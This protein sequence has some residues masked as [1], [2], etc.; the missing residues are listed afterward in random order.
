MTTMPTSSIAFLSVLL[1]ALTAGCT[2][3][4]TCKELGNCGGPVPVGD[5]VLDPAHPSCSENLYIPPG[6][7]RL[8][9]GDQPAARIPPADEALY[10]WCDLLVT[11]GGQKV[12]NIEPR[13]SYPN[14]TIGAAFF[15]YDPIGPTG[16]GTYS[17]GFTRTGRY[18]IEFPALCIRQFGAVGD[19]C[20]ALQTQLTQNSAHKDILCLANPPD[21]A[22][23]IC[24][25]D[26]AVQSGGSGI[27]QVLDGHTLIHEMNL[28]FPSKAPA[29][30]FP[31]QVTYCNKG[32]SLEITGANGAYLFDEPGLRTMDLASTTINC[33]DGAKGPA[34]EGVDCGLACPMACPM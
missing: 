20:T 6:D 13:F 26:V 25:F 24:Q 17:A 1:V 10:D 19:V 3:E 14:G 28:K 30:A 16:S 22:G 8:E 18:Y 32:G 15:H 5:W 4:P 21:P 33:T 27:Y 7:T 9:R 2:Q 29:A 23:C 12:A 34:E 31:Q 11:N